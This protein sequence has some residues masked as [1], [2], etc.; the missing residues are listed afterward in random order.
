M[1]FGARWIR[2]TI[3]SVLGLILLSLSF[4][5]AAGNTV[6]V[7]DVTARSVFAF[8]PDTGEVIL[9]QDATTRAAIGSIA[10]VMTTLVVMDHAELDDTVTILSEDMVEP[11]YSAMGLQPGDTLTVE[12]LLTGLLVASG[13]DASRAL[14][15]H[16]GSN[17]ANTD[18]PEEPVRAFVDLM[19]D[20]AT[21]I[22]LDDTR[23]ANPD[24]ED[25]DDAW[26]TARDVAIMF[27]FLMEDPVLA[28]MVGEVSYDFMSVGAEATPYTGQ[29]T[30]QLGSESGV[31]GAKTGSE[32]NAGG[33]IV[34]AR[35]GAS[36]ATEIIAILGSD[37]EYDETTWTATVDERW[38]DARIV[39]EAIDSHWTP[40]QN[41]PATE[42]TVEPT[43]EPAFDLPGETPAPQVTLAE[44]RPSGGAS[45]STAP[46]LAVAV[47]TGIIGLA[48][49]LAWSRI[50][51]R[52]PSNEGAP[53][54]PS[55][56]EWR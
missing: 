29:T 8:D 35:E 41:L 13:G 28:A 18:D 26:S 46:I 45:A 22:H 17:V 52:Q 16:V 39:M 9:E 27:A 11:G 53:N 40:G 19:N 36:G 50:I 25:D 49:V 4:L 48:G 30:N 31:I 20:K 34:L 14:A 10:K 33:C 43:A 6:E 47:A 42:P 44:S 38:T 24:G 12:Q 3:S 32:T 55:G 51:P 21:E 54:E 37:L 1:A 2:A 5:P 23:F 15:R 56:T 7:P